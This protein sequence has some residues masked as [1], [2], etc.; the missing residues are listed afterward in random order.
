MNEGLGVVGE[1]VE[2][3]GV[4]SAVVVQM[5]EED[6]NKGDGL[7]DLL[8]NGVVGRKIVDTWAAAAAAAVVV[9]A[10]GLGVSDVCEALNL[11][12]GLQ[13]R[14]RESWTLW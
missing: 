3:D 7:W 4:R 1:G 11:M 13:P 2:D 12:N 5:A 10:A 14:G 9:D 8:C 6:R